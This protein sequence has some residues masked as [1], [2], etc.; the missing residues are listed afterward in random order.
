MVHGLGLLRRQLRLGVAHD[1]DEGARLQRPPHVRASRRHWPPDAL[2]D[3]PLWHAVVLRRVPVACRHAFP[4]AAAA[5]LCP[6]VAIMQV[7]PIEPLL[8]TAASRAFWDLPKSFVVKVAKAEG[9]PLPAGA[10]MVE[11]LFAVI[12]HAFP[13][14]SEQDVMEVLATRHSANDIAQ[15]FSAALFEVE[16]A[17]Q[18]LHVDDHKDFRDAEAKAKLVAE[19]QQAFQKEFNAQANLV[20]ARTRASKRGKAQSGPKKEV[21][22]QMSQA[23]AKRFTPSRVLHL[24]GCV[25]L[26][27]GGAMR[28]F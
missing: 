8:R 10:N 11:T 21:P 24:E 3:L 18:C 13:E 19:G 22:T 15:S 16:E 4:R 1:Q 9:I 5:G 14:K 6:G 12:A 2:G 20:P 7:G 27:M 26:G 17:Y 25:A 23:Q 28:A